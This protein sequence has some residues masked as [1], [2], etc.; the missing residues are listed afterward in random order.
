VSI[1]AQFSLASTSRC[2]A[3]VSAVKWAVDNTL[4]AE[5]YSAAVRIAEAADATALRVAKARELLGNDDLWTEGTS[6]HTMRELTAMYTDAGPDTPGLCNL[7]IVSVCG[8]SAERKIA[9]A[10]D[11]GI[12]FVYTVMD[13]GHPTVEQIKHVIDLLRFMIAN[14][15]ACARMCA[16]AC[17]CACA[18]VDVCVCVCVCMCLCMCVRLLVHV[19]WCVFVCVCVCV[20]RALV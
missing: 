7:I 6:G 16:C 2:Y 20:V 9:L 3:L 12:D 5:S 19:C 8:F 14:N 10:D 11:G 13:T 4:N 1:L 15:S 17:L 18:L